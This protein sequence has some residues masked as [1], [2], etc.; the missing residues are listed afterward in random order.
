MG[1]SR[2]VT[3]K[4]TAA[5]AV[6]LVYT[7]CSVIMG[8]LI[9]F[10]EWPAWI[11]AGMILH[12]VILTPFTF[13]PK[14]SMRIQSI[15]MMLFTF[16]NTFT[17]SIAEKNI[18]PS[19]AVFLGAAIILAAYRSE[20]LLAVY[21]LLT[22]GGIAY[23]GVVLKTIPFDSSVRISEF[24]IRVSVLFIA[25]IFLIALVKGINR[26][27]AAMLKSVEDARQAE[28]YKT[29]FIANMSH[30][31]RTPMNSIIGMCE[32]ILRENDLSENVREDCFNIRTSGR[33]LLAIINDILDLS[34]IES[35][36]M[37]IVNEE[38][39]IA[40]L[41]NDVINM[42]EARRGAKEIEI[43]AD[44]DPN[45]PK[46]LIG[47]EMRIR[48]VIVNLMTNAVKFTPSGSVTL[49][50]S[51]TP[52]DYGINLMVSVADTGIGITEENMEKLFTSFNQ[53][54]TKKNRS[55]E[56]TGL[57]LAISKRLVGYMGGFINVKSQYGEG[58]E[59]RFVIP[60]KVS[61][62]NPFAAINGRDGVC[63]AACFGE[64]GCADKQGR[65]FKKSGEGLGA[66]FSWAGNIQ[67]LKALAGQKKLTH[68]FVDCQVYIGNEAFFNDVSRETHVFVLQDRGFAVPLP[69]GVARIFKPFYLIPA[70]SAINDEHMVI[71][72][73]ERRNADIRFTAPEARVLVVDDNVINLKV[74]IGLL[75]PYN[76]QVLTAQSGPEAIEMLR[77]KDIDIVFMDHMMPEMDGVEAA[78]LIREAD[79]EYFKKL[80]IIALTANVANGARELFLDSGFDDFLAKPIELPALDR[81]LRN[82]LPREYMQ[83][84]ENTSYARGDRRSTA[85]PEPK[86]TTL[87]D[88]DQGI[89]GVGG[90]AETYR[91]ILSLYAE[92]SEEKIK[93]IDGML[94]REDLPNYVIEVHGL[95]SASRSIGAFGLSELAK[96]LE[97]A[98]KAGDIDTLKKKNGELIKL[99]RQVSETARQYHDGVDRK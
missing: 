93:Q 72:L 42:S 25:Q 85:V 78:G 29:E 36:K 7:F 76:M 32:L 35:G 90:D 16:I 51:Y 9:Y 4:R 26:N 54:D 18:Y 2:I 68:V 31:I 56:G 59:F 75:Q 86:E 79:G 63:A 12:L 24:V 77:S 95:K 84:T 67:E 3:D 52:H 30:E 62:R 21:L 37:E 57:G 83:P 71:N 69:E 28:R 66:D 58:S 45:I 40:S 10:N 8:A 33:S 20:K 61:D 6:W 53:V 47:D 11:M 94:E 43:L 17:C 34:K 1:I 89:S 50:V 99:Y 82:F 73:N 81:I 15:L 14:A 22:A 65:I 97:E 74:A 64:T 13:Y 5:K 91:E 19:L 88:V 44:V 92:E 48:Q 55:V 49:T 80:P 87:L 46:G 98:G 23:H 70:I 96:E 39:N 27:R 60:L 38:F 41:I